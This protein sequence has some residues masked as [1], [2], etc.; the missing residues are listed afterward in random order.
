MATKQEIAEYRAG[1]ARRLLEDPL[2]NEAVR[3]SRAVKLEQ[4]LEAVAKGE[5]ALFLAAQVKAIDAVLTELTQ[6]LVTATQ[7]ARPVRMVV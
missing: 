7:D 1:E 3:K 4:M 2:L 5:D 6:V